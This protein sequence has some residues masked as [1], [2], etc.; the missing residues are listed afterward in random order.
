MDMHNDQLISV[1]GQWPAS[2]SVIFIRDIL[3][4]E[5]EMRQREVQTA[6]ARVRSDLQTE[7]DRIE[8]EKARHQQTEATLAEVSRIVWAPYNSFVAAP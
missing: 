3:Q 2:Y 1:P 7:V 5:V 4:Q 8:A 6:V